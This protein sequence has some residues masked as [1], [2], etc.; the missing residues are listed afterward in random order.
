VGLYVAYK[1]DR[2]ADFQESADENGREPAKVRNETARYLDGI[3]VILTKKDGT[4]LDLTD[5]GGSLN[6][7][8]G[9]TACTKSGIFH[10]VIPIEEMQSVTIG[11]VEI[12]VDSQ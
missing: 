9:K 5:S 7:S 2:Q 3:S 12:P 1:A 6:P 10:E 8:D 11:G 4:K